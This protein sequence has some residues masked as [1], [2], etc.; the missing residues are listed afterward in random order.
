LSK[1]TK[2]ELKTKRRAEKSETA[3]LKE[4]QSIK[5]QKRK[6]GKMSH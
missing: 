4:E 5:S 1:I 2:E 6:I 3:S